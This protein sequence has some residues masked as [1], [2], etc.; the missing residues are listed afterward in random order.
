MTIGLL[1]AGIFNYQGLSESARESL[2]AYARRTRDP[3]H[4]TI[5]DY[6]LGKQT[7]GV[8]KKQAGESP[9]NLITFN[10]HLGFW[11]EGLGDQSR[12]IKHYK[13]AL[14]SFLDTWLEYDFVKERLKKL[15]KP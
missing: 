10:T 3:W 12:A 7:E 6:L 9:E 11:A 4:L 2:E 15:K 14:E 13:E 1:E 8:L 5:C